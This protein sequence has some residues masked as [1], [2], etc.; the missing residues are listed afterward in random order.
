MANTPG[1][2]DFPS[3]GRKATPRAFYSLKLSVGALFARR[4]QA[5][6]FAG[7]VI[8]AVAARS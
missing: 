3:F 6:S 1:R 8:V 7:K 2:I 4:L 5:V